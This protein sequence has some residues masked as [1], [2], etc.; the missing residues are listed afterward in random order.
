MNEA[1]RIRIEHML[2]AA[3]EVVDFCQNETRE[4]LDADRMLMRAISMSI[5]IV[6]EGA[7][8]LSEELRLANPNIPWQLIVAM[9]NFVMHE[10][11]RLELIFCGKLRQ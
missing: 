2:E 6:G 1:D 9:R 8:R 4:S 3:R 10:Y 5:A 7:S 11:F